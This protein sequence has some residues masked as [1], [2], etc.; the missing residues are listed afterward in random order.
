MDA[1]GQNKDR[2]KDASRPWHARV[3]TTRRYMD[4]WRHCYRQAVDHIW[5]H[6]E[7]YMYS[8]DGRSHSDVRLQG[9][10]YGKDGRVHTFS[11]S[12]DGSLYSYRQGPLNISSCILP[13]IT[14]LFLP[15]CNP[16]RLC[17]V[18][19]TSNVPGCLLSKP[20]FSS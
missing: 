19:I 13:T 6:A 12:R 8:I 5:L 15:E 11:Y 10:V 2:C 7:I 14:I 16:L 18:V 1:S 9:N 20:Q 4:L 3:Y 17:S